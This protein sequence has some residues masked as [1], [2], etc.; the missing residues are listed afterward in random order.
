VR[1]SV[2]GPGHENDNGRYGV[3]T[4][5]G[6]R[7]FLSDDQL[8]NRLLEL[9]KQVVELKEENLKLHNMVHKLS[10][11]LGSHN[12]LK[13]GIAVV[14]SH[15]NSNI[16]TPDDVNR[17]WHS[18]YSNSSSNSTLNDLAGYEPNT[19]H[20]RLSILEQKIRIIYDANMISPVRDMILDDDDDGLMNKSLSETFLMEESD[21]LG[22]NKDG[23]NSMV[24]SSESL[25]NELRQVYKLKSQIDSITNNLEQKVITAVKSRKPNH[26]TTPSNKLSKGNATNNRTPITTNITKSKENDD[27]YENPNTVRPRLWPNSSLKKNENH[28]TKPPRHSVSSVES[29]KSPRSSSGGNI[30]GNTNTKKANPTEISKSSKSHNT[31]QSSNVHLSEALNNFLSVVKTTKITDEM[32]S[33]LLILL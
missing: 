5:Q 14:S 9:E 7:S 18:V 13:D 19:I 27:P 28:T 24:L 3:N 17:T 33:P 2:G 4:P 32:V 15:R 21:E 22:A 23:D 31:P 20:T 12:D 10:P 26:F 29:N 30:G 16:S 8:N 25:K 1:I 6:R 11:I